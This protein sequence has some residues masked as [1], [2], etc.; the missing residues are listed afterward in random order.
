MPHV[1]MDVHGACPL[2]LCA[3]AADMPACVRSI[4]SIIQR[5]GGTVVGHV[6][7]AFPSVAGAFTALFLLS[8]SHLSVHT[9]P[10]HCFVAVDAFTCGSHADPGLM[11]RD[12][13]TLFGACD[14]DCMPQLI[15]RG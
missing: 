15:L 9:W 2:R 8:E 6:A 7:H 12:L 13:C 5:H 10:E 3:L 1:V 4:Q 11:C 14:D